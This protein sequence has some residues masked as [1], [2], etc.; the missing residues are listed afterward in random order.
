MICLLDAEV[1]DRAP[2]IEI[3]EAL[4]LDKQ[5]WRRDIHLQHVRA[6][7]VGRE[8]SVRP[9]RGGALAAPWRA[10]YAR[11]VPHGALVSH[12]EA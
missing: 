12:H 6:Y 2:D 1:D 5:A 7:E 8:A 10:R 3:T 11:R 9:V 4:H